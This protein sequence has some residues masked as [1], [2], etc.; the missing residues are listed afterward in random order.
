MRQTTERCDFL[1]A[2]GGLSG[3]CA[4]VQAARLGLR[5][6][7]AEKE[8]LL[9][10]NAGPN[11]G[12]AATAAMI[13]NPYYNEMGL[14][15]EIEECVNARGARMVPT[16][17]NYNISPEVDA[18]LSE[19][20]EEA[21]VIV[22]RRHL[23]LECKKRG[24]RIASVTL[25]NLE[26]LDRVHVDT[27]GTLI[28]CT[29]EAI[30]AQ[31]AGA[32][33]AMGR[34]GRDET[35]ERSAP[36]RA[37]GI[38]S[39]ASLTA[40]AV[41]TGVDCPFVPP[42]GTPPWN[43]EKPSSRFD[44]SQKVHFL[45]QVDEGGENERNHPAYSPQA[46]YL[47]LTRRIFSQWDYLKNK[48]Y[49]EELR[50]H[51]LI[52]ISPILGR[53]ESRRILGD[54]L[55]SQ[56]DIEDC[57]VFPD[58]VA[59]GGSFLDEHLP[60]FDGGYEVRY[61][62][63][64]LPY[65]IPYRCIYSRNVENLFSGGRAVGVSHLAFTSVRLIRTGCGLAQA[66][67]AAAALC[68]RHRCTPRTVGARWMDELRQL[69]LEQDAYLP[70]VRADFKDDLAREAVITADSEAAIHGP[71]R[72]RGSWK[73][74]ETG[75]KALL[76]TY[77]ER[78]DHFSVWLRNPGPGTAAVQAQVYLERTPSQEFWPAPPTWTDPVSGEFHEG[79]GQIAPEGTEEIRSVQ[80][81]RNYFIRRDAVEPAERLAGTETAVPGG[82]EGYVR[83]DVPC[84]GFPAGERSVWRQAVSLCVKGPV[85]VLLAPPPVDVA[86]GWADGRQ[87]PETM[88]VIRL[89]PAV[90]PS[91]AVQMA[92]GFIHREGQSSL[93]A[94]VS[95]LPLPQSAVFSWPEARRI[96]QVIL[97][98]DITERLW[99]DMYISR[100]E[101]A[102]ARLAKGFR[103]EVMREDGRWSKVYETKENTRRFC[104]VTLEHPELARALR[105]TVIETW[106]GGPA[107][108]NEVRIYAE[109]KY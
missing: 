45:W 72:P 8:M 59:F 4:A 88:P 7:L 52:W 67:G 103:L 60:S 104:A 61:Y 41:D 30:L 91:A 74:A 97:H 38:V 76:F 13:T 43:P 9:G 84:G 5:V 107:R 57:R 54:Y 48:R 69:L 92:D 15:E 23:V 12:V 20:L 49:P 19:M 14:I 73:S 27:P 58:A 39:A 32:D 106:G 24:S 87:T 109:R 100:L 93:H 2:G 10:G 22:Y 82:F 78:I 99:R 80:G 68:V 36:E 16:I 37:D 70:G 25:L 55:L 105:L 63:R 3:I 50:T 83:F 81:C 51:Q 40:V 77:P 71:D 108:V 95:A 102:P 79:E 33:M 86:E 35:G 47:R 21:G 85:E 66:A 56:T 65:D 98:F 96:G 28:D 64:P 75:V 11:M 1:V 90:V 44:P 6:I 53:R 26:N 18:V 42:A 89:S 34:E 46:L 62:A 17:V 94:W 29:G 31:L 101:P